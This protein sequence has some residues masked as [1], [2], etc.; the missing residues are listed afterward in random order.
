MLGYAAILALAWRAIDHGRLLEGL[1]RLRATHIAL[2]LA[3]ALLHVAGR[4]L[5]FHRL[6]LR[7]HPTEYRWTD[8]FA[9]FL[10]GLSTSAVT[11]A[12]AGDFVKAQLVRRHG[13]GFSA[14]VGLVL[15]ERMLDLLSLT[16]AI[17][18]AGLAM[19]GE[20]VASWLRAAVVLLA[21][22]V[23]GLV[24]LTNGRIRR[25]A[26]ELLGRLARRLDSKR[27]E[28][29][30]EK[31][32]ATFRTWDA[33]FTFPATLLAYIAGSAVIWS[34]EFAKLWCLLALLGS[35]ASLPVVFFVYPV[36]LLAGVLTIL[37]FSEGVVG[38]TG[39]ALLASLGKIEPA[40]ATVAIVLDRGASGL[41]PILLA[42]T[43]SL[44]RGGRE[45]VSGP[46]RGA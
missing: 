16:G 33:V 15:I 2:V 35:P 24:V 30:A 25:A 28:G 43:S 37:P 31:F 8:G 17:L 34:I 5:R 46:T 27:A 20:G 45:A 39:V 21:L 11:P 32:Q 22:L 29:L 1:G 23:V 3:I 36:S 42:A 12:R 40:A 6:L 19:S 41:P 38:V 26:T 10:I 4:A 14:G 7:C 9:I 13:V 18:V 44:W